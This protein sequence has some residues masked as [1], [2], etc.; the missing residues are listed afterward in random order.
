MRFSSPERVRAIFP[1]NIAG[2]VICDGYLTGKLF[3]SMD[4]AE[5]DSISSVVD[6]FDADDRFS[7][8][9]PEIA[10]TD[11][12]YRKTLESMNTEDFV[13]VMRDTIYAFF[14]GSY[15]TLG[16]TEQMLQSIRVP[17]MVMPGNNDVHPR[18]V[19]EM[20]HRLVPNCQWAEVR[21]HSEE[22][23]KYTK[24]VLRFLSTVEAD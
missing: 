6:A 3:K 15:P 24:R 13:Q 11:A 21:P 19:A 7:P 17:A 22:P 8:F 1:S 23:E 16:M 4:M 5:N 20:V 10:Q 9:S 12:Q 14:D 18:R 2:G